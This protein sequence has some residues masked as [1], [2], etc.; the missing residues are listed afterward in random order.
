[1]FGYSSQKILVGFIRDPK[2]SLRR[3]IETKESFVLC[4]ARLWEISFPAQLCELS[5]HGKKM[6]VHGLE[7]QGVIRAARFKNENCRAL[8]VNVEKFSSCQMLSSICSGQTQTDTIFYCKW[9]RGKVEHIGIYHWNHVATCNGPADA[10]RCGMST[11]D[12]QFLARWG[13]L[14]SWQLSNFVSCLFPTS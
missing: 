6:I 8:T 2:T 14:T 11:D 4:K 3:D 5:F 9:C 13:V 10:G 12:F 1:M 7:L